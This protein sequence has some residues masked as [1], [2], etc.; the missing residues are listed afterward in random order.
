MIDALEVGDVAESG[1]GVA[2][3][4]HPLRAE[5]GYGARLMPARPPGRT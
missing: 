2:E 3:L 5:L 1:E 4:A